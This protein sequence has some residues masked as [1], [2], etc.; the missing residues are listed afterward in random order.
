MAACPIGSVWATG[1]WSDTAWECFTWA[2]ATPPPP[3]VGQSPRGSRYRAS[4][5]TR[6]IYKY[7]LWLLTLGGLR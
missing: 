7:A 2:D 6:M 4:F 3:V 5:N 1:S